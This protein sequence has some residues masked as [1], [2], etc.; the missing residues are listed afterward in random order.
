MLSAMPGSLLPASTGTATEGVPV[1]VPEGYVFVMGDNS[2]S[3]HDSRYWGFVPE[4][5]ILGKAEII[6]WPLNRIR[7]I[8]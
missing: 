1:T 7:L 2:G 4:T 5:D 8:K 3:S 6:F